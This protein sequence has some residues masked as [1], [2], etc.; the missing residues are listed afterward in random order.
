MKQL[1]ALKVF[2]LVFA[3][4][5][6]FLLHTQAREVEHVYHFGKPVMK[7][8]GEYQ[9]PGLDKTLSTGLPGNPVLPYKQVKLL[10]PPGESATRIEIELTD[11]VQLPGKFNIYPQQ[12]CRPLSEGS[13]GVFKKDMAVYSRNAF[14]PA[15]ARGQL[16]TAFLNGKSFALSSFTPLRYNPVTGM[17]SY[18]STVKVVVYTSPDPKAAN[19]LANLVNR[20]AEADLLPDNNEM[21]PL[22]TLKRLA[23]NTVYDFLI[24]CTSDYRNAFSTMQADYQ[25]EG[26][27]SLVVTLD[28][29]SSV[30]TG[31]D[32]QEKI[33][34]FIIEMYRNH[35]T[36]YVLLAGDDELIPHRGFYCY[37]QSGTG[38]SDQNIPSD[39]YYSALDG[40]WNENNNTLWGEPG[41]E[42]L[43]PDVAVARLPFSNAVELDHMLH[44]SHSY[45]FAPVAGEFRHVLMAGES[46]YANPLTYGSD[47]LNLLK[48]D[49]SDNGYP[50][51]GIPADYDF[52]DMYDEAG[53]WSKQ[54]LL[55]H[56]NQG[57][58]W[59]DHAGHANQV[60]T[61]RLNATDIIDANFSGS[62]GIDHNFSVVYSHGCDCA[63][64][65]ANDCIAEKMLSITNFAAAFIGNSRYGWFNEGQ[66]EGPSLHLNREFINAMYADS[67][68]RIGMAHKESKIASAAWVTA[69]GQWEPGA[70]RWCFY[71]C[72]VLGDPMMAVFTDNPVAINASYP[73]DPATDSQSIQVTA[74]AAGKP[75]GKLTCVLMKDGML[76]GKSVTDL[77]GH[78]EI[79]FNGI[80][81]EPGNA[82][83]IVSGYNCVPKSFDMMFVD[84]TSANRPASNNG[85]MQIFPNPASGNIRIDAFV[86]P[87]DHGTLRVYNKQGKLVISDVSLQG[88]NSGKVHQNLDIK[89]LKP[90]MYTCH[91]ISR[92]G[93]TSKSFIVY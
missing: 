89:M 56:M 78:A 68:N 88:D 45:Q 66:T 19:A 70:L 44:K 67:M 79:N 3:I 52:D 6:L 93:K 50:T 15:D 33:R 90:G 86:K 17:L 63:A 48:G 34:N 47:Y 7:Q 13:S 54:D 72:N 24:V 59:I 85:Q 4:F 28:S 51:A 8:V 81:I 77:S 18:Y 42:D 83:L 87:N 26:F 1:Q 23:P 62:N 76:I 37:V 55:N 36:K 69:P 27:S 21:L 29:I 38:Y 43:L 91:I 60:Y 41:E 2:S 16:L 71:D 22:Y 84:Y 73:D 75:A 10:L 5:F 92:Q 20:A 65:D 11:E 64:F 53:T 25:K 31:V 9:V 80:Q 35:D 46:L 32:I 14:F 61:M 30:M 49:H 57:R 74:T 58:P 40:S 82:Q 12:D 39:L